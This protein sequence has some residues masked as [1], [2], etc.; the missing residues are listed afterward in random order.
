[1]T[2][3]GTP[4]I[5]LTRWGSWSRFGVVGCLGSSVSR[6]EPRSSLASAR[7]RCH[8]GATDSSCWGGISRSAPT[9]VTRVR[10]SGPS[11]TQEG[12]LRV[13][14]RRT[15]VAHGPDAQA[16][17]ALPRLHRGG[18]PQLAHGL[19][20]PTAS[21][22]LP[23]GAVMDGPVVF[24]AG[25]PVVPGV[26]VSGPPRGADRAAAIGEPAGGVVQGV[27]T[28]APVRH[29]R[30]RASL[31]MCQSVTK[32]RSAIGNITMDIASSA[33]TTAP[34]ANSGATPRTLVA[35]DP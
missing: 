18:R 30:A 12:P 10:A 19:Q 23:R 2:Y 20:L 9:P 15:L 29:F 22:P 32:R 27:T 4:G 26:G 31:P 11:S 35:P 7:G 1:M 33:H 3:P 17:P 34:E 5:G 6:S 13:A 14:V 25:R 28:P 16:R 21:H 8:G 24:A